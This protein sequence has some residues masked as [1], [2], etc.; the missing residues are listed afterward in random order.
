MSDK[1]TAVQLFGI[2]YQA[3]RA[4]PY[5]YIAPVQKDGVKIEAVRGEL[6]AADGRCTWE[7]C[8]CYD[9]QISRFT[10]PAAVKRLLRFNN[11]EELLPE[12]LSILARATAEVCGDELLADKQLAADNPQDCHVLPIL[13]RAIELAGG[14]KIAPGTNLTDFL[15]TTATN[16]GNQVVETPPG[17]NPVRRVWGSGVINRLRKLVQILN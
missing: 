4:E 9:A 5:L 15:D 8:D 13:V 3:F 7:A 16:V 17:I 12:C 2:V 1:L 6:N 10:I 11:S 14:P